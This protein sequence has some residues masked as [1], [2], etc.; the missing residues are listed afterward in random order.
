MDPLL[1]RLG[2]TSKGGTAQGSTRK[3]FSEPL[4]RLFKLE[5]EMV[6]LVR[7]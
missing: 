5:K 2:I 1:K 3:L 7:A 6:F 4:T